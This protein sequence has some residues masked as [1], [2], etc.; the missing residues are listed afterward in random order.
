MK[1]IKGSNGPGLEK[2]APGRKGTRRQVGPVDQAHLP[3]LP[4]SSV[5]PELGSPGDLEPQEAAPNSAREASSLVLNTWAQLCPRD[6]EA[7][8]E[9]GLHHETGSSLEDST[10]ILF[11][12]RLFF[13]CSFL[14]NAL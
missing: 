6:A 7:K 14:F 11:L 10:P 2:G 5:W 12:S 3:T 1:G 8:H 9:P 13:S 4:C